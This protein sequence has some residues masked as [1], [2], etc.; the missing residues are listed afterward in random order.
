M[1]HGS[2][3]LVWWPSLSPNLHPTTMLVNRQLWERIDPDFDK[4]TLLQYSTTVF[5]TPSGVWSGTIRILN[6]PITYSQYIHWYQHTT[7]AS[8]VFFIWM[9]YFVRML[10]AYEILNICSHDNDKKTPFLG[11]RSSHQHLRMRLGFHGVRGTDTCGRWQL[12]Q[13][14]QPY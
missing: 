3:H 9:A 1:K 10:T 4:K 5:S 2:S 14:G 8:I 6:L 11:W 13:R 12:C 7:E